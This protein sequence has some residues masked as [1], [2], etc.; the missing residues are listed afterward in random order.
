MR[1]E[2][3]GDLGIAIGPVPDHNGYARLLE[4]GL[5]FGAIDG[6]LFIDLASQAPIGREVSAP[7]TAVWAGASVNR[8]GMA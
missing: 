3:T 6:C 4:R 1:F 7:M 2:E 8:N 5:G